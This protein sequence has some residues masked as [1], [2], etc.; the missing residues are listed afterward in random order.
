MNTIEYV[1]AE[2]VINTLNG[3]KLILQIIWFRD[4]KYISSKK[5]LNKFP[6]SKKKILKVQNKYKIKN[7]EKR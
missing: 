3:S 4:I 5:K 7:C 2:I 6:N 1:W